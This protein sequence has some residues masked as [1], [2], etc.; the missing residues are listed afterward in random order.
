MSPV[1]AALGPESPDEDFRQAL[2]AV[3][4]HDFATAMAKLE[5]VTQALSNANSSLARRQHLVAY[6]VALQNHCTTFL[7]DRQT[8][9]V[10]LTLDGAGAPTGSQPLPDL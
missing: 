8:V 1:Q 6:G 2:D 5:S 4:N 10:V 7:V 3:P 9:P